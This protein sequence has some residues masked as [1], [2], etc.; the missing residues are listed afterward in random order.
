MPEVRLH[1]FLSK[2]S[3]ITVTLITALFVFVLTLHFW[4][5]PSVDLDSII[6]GIKEA[7]GPVPQEATFK[8]A[9]SVVNI[10]CGKKN[11]TWGSGV[12]IEPDG[13]IL[14]NYHNVSNHV[15]ESCIV[16]VP[17]SR[18]GR[19]SEIYSARP[20][21]VPEL[22]AK[23][24]LALVKIEGPYSDSLGTYGVKDKIFT[25]YSGCKNSFPEVGDYVQVYGY[26][27][28]G[29]SAFSLIATEGIVSAVPDDGTIIT[30]AKVS[31]GNSGGLAL[32]KAGCVIGMPSMIDVN[33]Y[34][35]YGVITAGSVLQEFITK[36]SQFL[37]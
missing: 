29:G 11:V 35:S 19:V 17:D 14:T 3:L 9:S 20:I 6:L 28:V 2:K 33:E 10:I 16:T 15:N 13:T 5:R 8:I 1:S 7:R 32:D 4:S 18:T 36:A 24:D 12:V 37:P 25:T 30:S 34:T 31:A 23:Y 26:P 27:S 21:V 22:S